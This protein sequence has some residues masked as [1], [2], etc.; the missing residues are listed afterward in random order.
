MRSARNRLRYPMNT[1]ESR[2]RPDRTT[3]GRISSHFSLVS[4]IDMSLLSSEFPNQSDQRQEHLRR[5]G[6]KLTGGTC[7]P[8]I[9]VPV[10]SS[11]VS[12]QVELNSGEDRISGTRAK[13][14][15]GARVFDIDDTGPLKINHSAVLSTTSDPPLR[16]T[17]REGDNSL[18]HRSATNCARLCSAAQIALT[19]TLMREEAER[20]AGCSH[21]FDCEQSL[22]GKRRNFRMATGAAQAATRVSTILSMPVPDR[23]CRWL[24]S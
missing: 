6:M 14:N 1:K 21:G 23:E 10:S 3:R 19:I 16:S 11:V 2:H 24:R 12:A 22:L 20:Y 7:G 17:F 15:S 18:T 4:L 9:R 5:T 13:Q 8:L